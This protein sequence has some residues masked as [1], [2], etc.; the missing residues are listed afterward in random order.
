MESSLSLH[1][2][3]PCMTVCV[4]W[5]CVRFASASKSS[6]ETDAFRTRFPPVSSPAI[7]YQDPL[8]VQDAH[9]RI[10]LWYLPDVLSK[11]RQVS[12]SIIDYGN[13]L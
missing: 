11:S 1:T 8:V 6:S 5:D 2:F 7:L 4:G 10:L 3:L 9:G 12:I 13:D